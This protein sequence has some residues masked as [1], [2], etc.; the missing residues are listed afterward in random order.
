MS[1]F[2]VGDYLEIDYSS[3]KEL[4]LIKEVTGNSY[5]LDFIF[6]NENVNSVLRTRS[7][8]YLDKH[9]RKLTKLELALK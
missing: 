9:A 7:I 4:Y 2:K 1:K 8:E 3:Y 5:L 6:N